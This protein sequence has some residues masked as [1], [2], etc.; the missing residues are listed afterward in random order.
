MNYRKLDCD[1][2]DLMFK[3]LET[4]DNT[5]I[6]NPNFSAGIQCMANLIVK[7]EESGNA[8]QCIK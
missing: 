6:H 2:T 3:G 8:L 1:L 4:P 5:M 7:I